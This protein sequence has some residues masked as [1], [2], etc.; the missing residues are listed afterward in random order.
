M[1]SNRGRGCRLLAALLALLAVCGVAGVAS[2][3]L[4][5]LPALTEERLG[6]SAANLN[7]IQE[8][9]L[10][11]YLMARQSALDAPAGDPAATLE[12]EVN[13]GEMASSVVDRLLVAGI[14]RD[15][16]L[17]R[18]Y[19]RYRGLDVGVEAGNYQLSGEMTVRE[20]AEALQT[21]RPLE[22]VF[23][24]PEGWRREQIAEA[25]P[26]SGLSFAPDDFLA[27]AQTRPPATY[28]FASE[29][30]DP[31]SLEGFLFPDTYHLDPEA[32][33]LDLVLAML[34]D[35]ER[36]VDPEL[37]LGFSQSGLS[38]YQAVT[39]AS[40]VEREAIQPDERP[41]IASVFLNRLATGMN[42]DA[43]PTIQYALGRQPD[44]VW[45]KSPLM[46]DD[47]SFD[48]P[49]NTYLYPGLPP[50]PIANPGLASLQAVAHPADTP[51]FYFRAL[52]DGSGRHV[53]AETFEE[54]LGN[55]CP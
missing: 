25:I 36:R 15:S 47:L 35:F 19:L 29:L 11:A 14:V 21:A 12:L 39:L 55:A 20:L 17:L 44:G 50:G 45:W 8:R 48:S 13:E 7:P 10:A 54:H 18:T 4:L 40:I 51:Y 6:P 24:V 41:V 38:L 52:C 46:L 49:Y 33:A 42:L 34:D 1:P 28:S 2:A 30:P 9:L 27:A 37:R 23:G 26:G 3:F 32:T 31:S 5:D 53:F 16:F 22:I 43:D